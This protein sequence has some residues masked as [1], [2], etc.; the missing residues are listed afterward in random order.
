VRRPSRRPQA[1]KKNRVDQ[2]RGRRPRGR[3]RKR[4]SGVWHVPRAAFSRWTPAHVVLRVESGRWSLRGAKVYRAVHRALCGGNLRE[5]FRLVQYSVQRNHFHLVPEAKDTLALSRGMQGLEIRLAH[6]LNRVMH[7]T[8]RV[9]ADRYRSR[10]ARCPEHPAL[11]AEQRAASRAAFHP[12]SHTL[13]GS[14]LFRAVVST[15]VRS[16]GHS[17]FRAGRAPSWLAGAR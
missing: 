12:Q 2:P 13:D 6:A 7:R 10:P 1:S 14:L 4:G 15:L 3:P 9:F 8:G 5:G 11:R 17:R 16:A